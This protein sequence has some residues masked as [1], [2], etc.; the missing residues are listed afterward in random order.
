MSE[1]TYHDF[2]VFSLIFDACGRF[3][4]LLMNTLRRNKIVV[5]SNQNFGVSRYIIKIN[6]LLIH[7]Y[8]K[9]FASFFLSDVHYQPCSINLVRI[10]NGSIPETKVTPYRGS[11]R[12]LRCTHH[13]PSD[14][15]N[16]INIFK[17]CSKWDKFIII[18]TRSY[19]II[20]NIFGY[21]SDIICFISSWVFR[22]KTLYLFLF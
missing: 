20:I 19:H 15:K 10:E 22:N 18:W 12:D 9:F 7:F 5:I 21:F 17:T 4:A 14:W 6:I 13:I 2:R 11:S 3:R 1:K 8:N 16:Q